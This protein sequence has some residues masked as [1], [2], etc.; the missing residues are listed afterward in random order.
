MAVYD[1]FFDAAVDPETGA[2]DRDYASGDFTQYFGQF[3]GSGVCIHGNPDS[4][5]VR[6]EDGRAVVSPGYLFL[7]GYWLKNDGD[8]AVDLPESG[9]AAVAAHLNLGRRRMELSAVPAAETYQDS[10][11]LALVDVDAG[12]LEDTRYDTGLCGVI[13]SAGGLSGKIS[14]ATDYID[15]EIAG[16]LAQIEADISEQ[17]QKMDNK[18]AE[19]GAVVE[20]IAPP[21]VGAIKFSAAQDVGEEWLRCDG[22]FVSREEYPELVDLLRDI[23]PSNFQKTQEVIVEKGI[24]NG[25]IFDGRIWAFSPED[26]KLYGFSE[27]DSSVK[28]IQV[29]FP[30][31]FSITGKK[32][33]LSIVE[34]NDAKNLYILDDSSYFKAETDS[35]GKITSHKVQFSYLFFNNFLSSL[36]NIDLNLETFESNSIPPLNASQPYMR[37]TNDE[38]RPVAVFDSIPYVVVGTL[39]CANKEYIRSGT[40]AGATF[41]SVSVPLLSTESDALYTQIGTGSY[42]NTSSSY[43]YFYNFAMPGNALLNH[44]FLPGND[45]SV[46]IHPAYWSYTNGESKS[47][48]INLLRG[49][50]VHILGRT[51]NGFILDRNYATNFFPVIG[52]NHI[53]LTY[54]YESNNK[55]FSCQFIRL[56]SMELEK[57]TFKNNEFPNINKFS[58]KAATY[59]PEN[60]LW[61]FI[62]DKGILFSS[63]LSDPNQY[64]F[65]DF[66]GNQV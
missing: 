26:K 44:A 24:T 38:Y 14:Y 45:G 39:V 2:F 59:I 32:F 22:R 36:S 47:T 56:S 3:I 28:E 11:V 61:A 31:G 49:T 65:F 34:H 37:G 7:Q 18:I 60:N 1:G 4:F 62:C 25:V 51:E 9:A 58:D 15:N 27:N 42:I 63:D 41:Y 43:V 29:E 17:E 30:S 46:F 21:P 16:K 8:Y 50:A 10:L 55:I 13:D 12:T 6:L 53:L 52:S 5:L 64:I 35:D 23:V 33:T 66:H 57:T 19:V 20:Q 54:K 48:Q 40:S